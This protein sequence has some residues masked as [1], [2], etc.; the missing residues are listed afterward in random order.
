[1]KMTLTRADIA[2]A[3]QND[4][5]SSFSHYG[6]LTLADHLMELEENLG[7]EI[8]FDAVAIRC[9]FSEYQYPQMWAED[10]F[11]GD[12]WEGMGIELTGDETEDEQE[13]LIRDYVEDH[14]T[15]LT[16]AGGVIVSNF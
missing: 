12:I 9:D 2:S 6:A 3:L 1:M 8:E 14:G 7:E 5:G 4:E 15:L 11:S 10:Y 13:A 16:F